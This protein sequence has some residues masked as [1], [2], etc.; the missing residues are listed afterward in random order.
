MATQLLLCRLWLPCAALAT[1]GDLAA[2]KADSEDN[3]KRRALITGITGQDGSYLAEILLSKGYEIHGM[4]RR[5]A[6]ELPEHRVWRIRHVLP[7][8]HLHNGSLES[9]ASLL[10]LLEQVQPDECYHLAAQSSVGYSFD[11]EFSTVNINASGTHALLAA[12]RQAAPRCKFCFAGSSE[13]YGQVRSSPQNEETPFYPRSSYGIAKVAAFHFC[14]HYRDAYKLFI[15]NAILF[16][17]ESP[18]R[19]PEFVSRKITSHAARIKLGLAKELQLG[20]IETRRDLGHAADSMEAMWMMLQ[21]PGP[22]DYV[23]A[24]GENHSIREVCEVAFHHVGLDYRDWLKINPALFRPADVE[25]LIGDSSKARKTL[26]W[27]HKRSWKDVIVEM[28][29]TDL[30][31]A[32]RADTGIAPAPLHSLSAHRREGIAQLDGSSN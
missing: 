24:T 2:N 3:V 32:G 7:E 14:Q 12:L 1:S 21:Q 31:Q 10:K 18:R 28:V 23:V 20:N 22:D 19:G 6:I 13:M 5:V 29:E 9:Y 26:G 17:H 4:V 8:V 30:E 25:L 11:D 27:R 15:S 16:D